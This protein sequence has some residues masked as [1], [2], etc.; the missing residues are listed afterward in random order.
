MKSIGDTAPLKPPIDDHYAAGA[1]TRVAV[2]SVAAVAS[3]VAVMAVTGVWL[4]A[5]AAPITVLILGH[6]HLH[7]VSDGDA[8]QTRLRRARHI[9]DDEMPETSRMYGRRAA[10]NRAARAVSALAEDPS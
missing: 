4:L 8:Y 5:L 9:R 6:Q 1:A 3:L 7:R 10:A 2:W